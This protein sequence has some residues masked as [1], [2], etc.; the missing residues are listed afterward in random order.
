MKTYSSYLLIH[1][2]FVTSMS[3]FF[4]MLWKAVYPYK[5]M[6]DW[7]KF[8]EKSLPKTEHFYSN[9]Y[10]EGITGVNDRQVKIVWEENILKMNINLY[11]QKFLTTHVFVNFWNTVLKYMN[12]DLLIVFQHYNRPFSWKLLFNP[13]H[14]M[15]HLNFTLAIHPTVF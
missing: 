2:S 10:I 1:M 8:S 3:I 5:Y 12:M 6:N 9:L 4:L 14:S 13:G 7:E 15:I 11:I